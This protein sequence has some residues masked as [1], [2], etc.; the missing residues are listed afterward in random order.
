MITNDRVK[1][2]PPRRRPPPSPSPRPHP[3]SYTLDTV[4]VRFRVPA[5][6]TAKT[7]DDV[8][9]RTYNWK[10]PVLTLFCYPS[11]GGGGGGVG[12]D[13]LPAAEAIS[14]NKYTRS[15][16][17]GQTV[18]YTL[19]QSLRAAYI[20]IIRMYICIRCTCVVYGTRARVPSLQ[21]GC[22]VQREKIKKRFNGLAQK[23]KKIHF[24]ERTPRARCIPVL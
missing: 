20:A 16:E 21:V 12:D 19:S 24:R 15:R 3:P 17:R 22:C 13:L 6:L 10:S 11:S 18:D 2:T 1:I 5:C 7:T 4:C 23:K 8:E 14:L 9:S